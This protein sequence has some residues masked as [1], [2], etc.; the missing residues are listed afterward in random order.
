MIR[1]HFQD[2]AQDC[3]WWDIN[4]EGV[5]EDCDMQTWLWKGTK[6]DMATPITPGCKLSVTFK[7]GKVGTWIHPVVKV[8]KMRLHERDQ[9][10]YDRLRAAG[11]P[12][13]HHES[14]LYALKTPE[15]EAIMKTDDHIV[16]TFVSRIDQKVWYDI[17]FAYKPFWDD[18]QK[19]ARKGGVA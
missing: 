9:S 19:R 15:S 14:D 3:L 1:V 16:T 4:E 6:V 13:D 17:P 11:V 10:L 8:E 7:D 18:V 12:L 2:D 5:V